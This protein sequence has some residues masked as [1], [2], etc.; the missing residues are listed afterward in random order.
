MT[1]VTKHDSSTLQLIL[2]IKATLPECFPWTSPWCIQESSEL[3]PLSDACAVQEVGGG[4]REKS[5]D[6]RAPAVN[7]AHALAIPFPFPFP[8]FLVLPLPVEGWGQLIVTRTHHKQLL[9]IRRC[10]CRCFCLARPSHWHSN[11]SSLKISSNSILI[12]TL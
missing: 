12:R 4:A 9:I 7:V 1:N 10:H 5:L 8:S 6:T 3:D 11:S 2:C